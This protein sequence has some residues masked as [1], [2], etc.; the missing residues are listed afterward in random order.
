MGVPKQVESVGALLANRCCEAVAQVGRMPGR[1]GDVIV[2]DCQGVGVSEVDGVPGQGHQG[3]EHRGRR[4]IHAVGERRPWVQTGHMGDGMVWHPHRPRKV[5]QVG[6]GPAVQAS[7]QGDPLQRRTTSFGNTRQAT[8]GSPG[9]L[10][11]VGG[12]AGVVGSSRGEFEGSIPEEQAA[13]WEALKGRAGGAVFGSGTKGLRQ[14]FGGGD[15]DGRFEAQCRVSLRDEICRFVRRAS[16]HVGFLF[17]Q[18]RAG[19]ANGGGAVGDD[20]DGAVVHQDGVAAIG[21]Q[22]GFDLPPGQSTGLRD[23]RQLLPAVLGQPLG[24]GRQGALPVHGGQG[25]RPRIMLL[26]G[27]LEPLPLFEAIMGTFPRCC[28]GMHQPTL[29]DLLADLFSSHGFDVSRDTAL[30]GRSGTLYTIPLLAEDDDRYVLVDCA[31]EEEPVVME[32]LDD[33]AAII[34]DV[35]ADLAV[36]A[37]IGPVEAAAA[38]ESP[39]ILWDRHQ[40]AAL[41][42]D[43]L[44]AQAV[45]TAPAALPLRTRILG[46]RTPDPEAAL[47]GLHDLLADGPDT[48]PGLNAVDLDGLGQ[49][50]TQAPTG[51]AATSAPG[52]GADSLLARALRETVPGT[53]SRPA[54]ARTPTAEAFPCLPMRVTLEQARHLIRDQISNVERAGLV[55]QPVWIFDYECDLLIE[56]TL[57]SETAFGRI[58]VHGTSRVVTAL[59][60]ELAPAPL[61]HLPEGMAPEERP[62]RTSRERALQEARQEVVAANTRVVQ[63]LMD[64]PEDNFTVSEKKRVEPRPDHVRLTCLGT[65]HRPIWRL[66]GVNGNVELDAVSGEIVTQ[67][68]R[69]S[70]RNAVMLE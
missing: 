20:P 53:T 48:Y 2:G 33:L 13:P 16:H 51:V 4:D 31:A 47:P 45:G 30:E 52:A 55:L 37:H 63:V 65:F 14:A 15:V 61:V 9:A 54:P 1:Q 39:V 67:Q 38:H 18:P 50:D 40:V 59:E 22:A 21:G 34:D 49:A 44:V 64:D 42:G 12:G 3:I 60:E 23:K 7:H 43:N 66:S 36:L 68:L 26:Q 24:G 19:P 5:R 27:P 56:G 6:F 8:V 46:R 70:S 29:R 28:G 17:R 25:R 11:Q 62:L 41:V 69:S 58:E 35:G 32:T 57:R 10:Q